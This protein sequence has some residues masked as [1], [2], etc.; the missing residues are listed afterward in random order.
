MHLFDVIK[1]YAIVFYYVN[2]APTKCFRLSLD[3]VTSL[4]HAEHEKV[5]KLESWYNNKKRECSN[6]S[7]TVGGLCF[8][9]LLS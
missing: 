6:V 9:A 2:T 4:S 5:E 3:N 7:V 1:Q 8:F